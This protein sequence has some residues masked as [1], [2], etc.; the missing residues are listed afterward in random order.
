LSS[1]HDTLYEDSECNPTETTVVLL[2][3]LKVAVEFEMLKLLTFISFAFVLESLHFKREDT[4]S[5]TAVMYPMRE[6]LFNSEKSKKIYKLQSVYLLMNFE[7]NLSEFKTFSAYLTN[8][9]N[10]I[11]CSS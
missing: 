3:F 5:L 4:W 1:Q 8:N 10:N 2:R 7:R 6:P 11:S 9:I